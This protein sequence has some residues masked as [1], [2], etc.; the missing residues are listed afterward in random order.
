ME[1]SMN[2]PNVF[3]MVVMFEDAEQSPQ[4]AREKSERDRDY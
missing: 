1:D 3:N 4:S 2:D